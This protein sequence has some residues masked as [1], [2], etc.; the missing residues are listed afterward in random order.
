MAVRYTYI[1][2]RCTIT[3]L[4]LDRYWATI[5]P[6]ELPYDMNQLF[7]K[8]SCWGSCTFK[9]DCSARHRWHFRSFV[10]VGWINGVRICKYSILSTRKHK[11]T[12]NRFILYIK[13]WEKVLSSTNAS[14][15]SPFSAV[16]SC[17][18]PKVDKEMAVHRRLVLSTD[19]SRREYKLCLYNIHWRSRNEEIG[20]QVSMHSSD[21]TF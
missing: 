11:Y 13:G 16:T 5:L 2:I 9:N 21:W 20:S 18:P 17:F 15:W 7:E 12:N 3:L 4:L 8:L 6:E 1:P 19:S 10:T 14:F